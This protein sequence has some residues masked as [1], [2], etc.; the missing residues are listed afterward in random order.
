MMKRM[1]EAQQKVWFSK[2]NLQNA[3]YCDLDEAATTC[4]MLLCLSLVV[5]VIKFRVFHR[6]SVMTWAEIERE[7]ERERRGEV[8]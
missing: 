1:I 5:G 7:R 3:I 8:N 4:C 2:D 6:V